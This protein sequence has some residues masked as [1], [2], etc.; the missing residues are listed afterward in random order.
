MERARA[1]GTVR[2]TLWKDLEDQRKIFRLL[3]IEKRI[4]VRLTEDCQMVPEQ[5][6]TAM[7]VHRNG[8][9]R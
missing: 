6:T 1:E 9:N 4:G 2:G 7:V 3:D 8:L 5:S